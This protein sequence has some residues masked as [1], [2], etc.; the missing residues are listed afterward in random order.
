M[1]RLAELLQECDLHLQALQE[2]MGRCPQP[3]TEAR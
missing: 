3:L 1:R 2:A